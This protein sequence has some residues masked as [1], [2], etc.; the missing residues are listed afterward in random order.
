MSIDECSGFDYVTDVLVVGSGA[1][2]MTAAIRAHDLG[3]ETLIIEK[4]GVYGGSSA[5]SGG[6]LWVPNNHLMRKAGIEDS[7]DDAL[8]Y[9]RTLTRGKVA[10]DRIEAYVDRAPEMLEYMTGKTRLHMIVMP[11]YP[12]YYPRVPGSRPGGRTVEPVRLDA[13]ELGAEFDLLRPP[14]LQELIMGRIAMTATEARE[15][16]GRRPG[17]VGLMTQIFGRYWLDV[18]GRLQGKRDRSLTLGNA[19][20]GWLRLSLMDRA[21]P[22]WLSTPARELIVDRGRVA[23]VVAQRG[24]REMRIGA[25]KGV[26]LGSGGFESSQAMRERFLPS[27]TKA[28]WTCGSPSNTGDAI[29]MGKAVGAALAMMDDAWWGPVTVVPGEDRARMLVI[30]KGLPG[31]I[32]VD[33]TGRRFVNEA[34]PYI[35]IVNAMYARHCDET[36][37]VPCYLVFDADYRRKYP[38]GP[39]LQASQQPD[40]ALPPALRRGYLVKADSL[41]ELAGQLG[42]DAD[43]LRHTVARFNDHARRGR[44]PEFGRGETVFDCYYGDHS[45]PLNPCLAPV[46]K[47]PFYG[48]AIYAGDLGTKGGLATDARARV[49]SE[50]GEPVPGLYAVGN[51]SASVMGRT[52]AGAGATIGPAMTFGFVAAEDAASA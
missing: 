10:D 7:R 13:R 17:W 39:F 38:C 40:W 25:R 21:V 3:A 2:A 50:T 37:A 44:D 16:L 9:L 48:M 8:E 32:L 15:M 33:K 24:G 30:E 47:P 46:A 22:L 41:S 4:S 23:G 42:I 20:I 26:I 14:A 1:G 45:N 49:L 27:P 12:D 18:G 11:A 31:C 36:P 43:G 5:M 6:A 51:C 19:L 28:E 35:D 34:A 29:T 52:Y